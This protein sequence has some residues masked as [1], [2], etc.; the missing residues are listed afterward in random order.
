VKSDPPWV[1]HSFPVQ[2]SQAQYTGLDRPRQEVETFCPSMTLSFG[3]RTANNLELA[4]CS[5]SDTNRPK[6]QSR[7]IDITA[8]NARAIGCAA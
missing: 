5:A 6:P 4:P 3:Q 7:L 2:Q 8:G 1:C